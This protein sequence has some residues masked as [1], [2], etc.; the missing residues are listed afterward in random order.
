MRFILMWKQTPSLA[1]EIAL[2][3]IR[4]FCAI[5]FGGVFEIYCNRLFVLL[6]RQLYLFLQRHFNDNK[7]TKSFNCRH[8]LTWLDYSSHQ[9]LSLAAGSENL[10][11]G[12]SKKMLKIY[13]MPLIL[14]LLTYILPLFQIYP[15]TY[16]Y[17]AL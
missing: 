6:T 17:G 1:I 12:I 16:Y 11:V 4:L 15:F 13:E 14:A 8:N 7:W 9:S 10:F 3:V 2:F 5:E